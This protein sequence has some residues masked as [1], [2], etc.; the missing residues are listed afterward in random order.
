M[1]RYIYDLDP[2]S[3]CKTGQ[4]SNLEH[5]EQSVE[6]KHIVHLYAAADKYDQRVQ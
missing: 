4:L 6:L 5:M 3:P 2:M 1:L